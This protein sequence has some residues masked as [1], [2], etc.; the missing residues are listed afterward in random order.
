LTAL[1]TLLNLAGLGIV[2]VGV[3]SLG[4]EIASSTYN[5][6]SAYVTNQTY[7]FPTD[8][9][10]APAGRHFYMTFWFYQYQRPSIFVAPNAYPIGNI[11]LPLPAQLMD[12]QSVNYTT[13]P[14]NPALGAAIDAATQH[15]HQSGGLI[16]SAIAG[17]GSALAGGA[18]G[19]AGIELGKIS[20]TTNQLLQ[21]GGLAINPYLTVLF[22]APVFKRMTFNWKFTPTSLQE[23]NNLKY[24]LNKFRYHQLPDTNQTIGGTLLQYPDMCV[25]VISPAGY[26]YS[27]KHCVIENAEVNYSPAATPGFSDSN[28]PSTIELTLQL[29]EIEYWLKKDFNN[30]GDPNYQVSGTPNT[31][32]LTNGSYAVL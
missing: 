28:A 32:N 24:I 21:I 9:I 10:N 2:A 25:P 18:A 12:K 29:L 8:L 14:M 3:T 16:N 5:S 13:T 15:Y 22:N 30:T 23:S 1:T 6:N 17:A 31:I 7:I 20:T 4:T 11:V 26:V 19:L 27:F